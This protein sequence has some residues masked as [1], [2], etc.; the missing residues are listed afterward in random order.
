VV[1]IGML[2]VL[3]LLVGVAGYSTARSDSGRVLGF[4]IAG[5]FAIPLVMLLFRLPRLVSPRYV[6]LDHAGLTIQHGRDQVVLPWPQLVAVGFGHE[7]AVPAS[8]RAIPTLAGPQEI[9][10]DYLAGKAQEALRVGDERRIAWRSTRPG[11]R[12]RRGSR[13][14]SRTGTGTFQPHRRPGW[15]A[16]PWS[17]S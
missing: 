1:T 2:V 14:S 15:Y 5:L 11:R 4:A 9:A 16:R 17:G 10:T 6:I 13:S 8:R 3:G 7:Q 12:P